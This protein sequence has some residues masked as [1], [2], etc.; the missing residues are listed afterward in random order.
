MQQ[1]FRNVKHPESSLS[2]HSTFDP[3]TFEVLN[4]SS[5]LHH[6]AQIQSKTFEYKVVTSCVDMWA[7]MTQFWW[8]RW[9]VCFA[10][11]RIPQNAF[12]EIFC[13]IL[14]KLDSFHRKGLTITQRTL[15]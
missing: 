11:A 5:K 4:Q 7:A 12:L 13:N 6:Q 15:V 1:N 2:K 9:N 10:S 3:T 14:H 8:L